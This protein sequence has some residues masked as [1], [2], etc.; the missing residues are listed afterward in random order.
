MKTLIQTSFVALALITGAA[1]ANAGLM[2]DATHG[3]I[4]ITV[5]GS[6]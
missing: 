3:P 4:M 6:R 2:I 1:S 5:D